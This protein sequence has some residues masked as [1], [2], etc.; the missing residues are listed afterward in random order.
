MFPITFIIVNHE[1]KTQV[2]IILLRYDAMAS[3]V[4]PMRY[5]GNTILM[6]GPGDVNVRIADPQMVTETE[7]TSR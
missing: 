6:S 1:A 3:V 5:N 4:E 7:N 2:H